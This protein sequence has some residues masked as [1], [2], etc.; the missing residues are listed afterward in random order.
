MNLIAAVDE[1][2]GIGKDGKLLFHIP[3]DLKFFK[4]KTTGNI[5]VIGR[6]TLESF[7]N[8]K[9]L[10]DRINIVL[11]HNS[12]YKADDIILCS[13][14]KGVLEGIKKYPD[15]EVFIAGG[16]SV[17]SEFLDYCDYAYITKVY[18]TKDADTYLENLDENNDWETVYKSGIK[19]NNDIKFQFLQYKRLRF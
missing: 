13:S 4:N 17:Y 6:K 12:L 9:A 8:G 18:S 5:I 19:Y 3:D 14:I 15:R 11:S 1:R 2:W 16:G 10:P 7:P